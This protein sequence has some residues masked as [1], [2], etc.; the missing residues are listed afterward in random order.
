M[1]TA[2]NVNDKVAGGVTGALGSGWDVT[3]EAGS[4]LT[5]VDGLTLYAGMS[6]YNQYQNAASANGDGSERVYGITYASGSF[7]AGVSKS[8]ED[9]GETG[10]TGYDNTMYSVTFNVNDDLSI[11]YNHVESDKLSSAAH[12]DAEANSLQAAYTMGGATISIAEVDIENRAYA[13][14]AQA[15]VSGTVVSLG[16]AF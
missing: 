13:T 4:E 16:L 9:T 12:G 5:G 15:D 2:G 8:T 6:E 11:G 1:L 3:L 7:T 14:T 10:T